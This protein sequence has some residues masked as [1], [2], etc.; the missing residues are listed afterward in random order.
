MFCIAFLAAYLAAYTLAFPEADISKQQAPCKKFHFIFARGSTEMGTMGSTVGPAFSRALSSKF[1]A[2]NVQTEGVRYPAD[3]AGAFTGGTNPSGAKGAIKMTEMAKQ[4]M[5]KCPTTRIILGGYSQG[6]EQVHGA[7]AKK[8][9]GQDGARIA[10]FSFPSL[11]FIL[12][13]AG[14][15][16]SLS[17]PGPED[18]RIFLAM[19]MLTIELFRLRRPTVTRSKTLPLDREHGAPFQKTEQ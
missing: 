12:F 13:S 3:I 7:L 10:V 4:V 19:S 14:S 1:G 9:L 17:P 6:A 16:A 15:G 11:L 18:G 8:N 5:S 2:A